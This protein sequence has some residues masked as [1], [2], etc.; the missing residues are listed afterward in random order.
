LR[1]DLIAGVKRIVVKIGSRVLTS[2]GEGLDFG[3]INHLVEQIS[4]LAHAGKE[5]FVVSSGAVAAGIK[6]LKLK[7]LPRTIPQK[8]AVA[9]VGQSHLIWAYEWAF[10][11]HQ[12][13]V[14]QVLLTH[15][16]LRHRARYLNARNTLLTLI[17][18]GTVP[19]INENDTVS[20]EEIKLGDN[21]SLSAMV[22]D[23]VQADLLLILTD[24]EGVYTADPCLDPTAIFLAEIPRVTP[25][26][27]AMGG[28][29]NHAVARGGMFTKIQAA[30]KLAASGI[31]TIVANGFRSGIIAALLAGESHGTL[32]HPERRLWRGRKR[33]IVTT[34]R[35]RGAVF[36]DEGAKTAVVSKG[37]SLLPSGILSV[38]GEFEFGDLVRCCDQAGFEFARG[39]VNYP[40]H[41]VR[42]IKGL[43]TSKIEPTLGHKYCD[44]VIHRDNLVVWNEDG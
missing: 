25:A 16:D 29:P 31:P 44:E 18:L 26:I 15:E 28:L 9:A 22:A 40:G 6:E 37:K 35:P 41:E 8:Q 24:I 3:V 42:L 19:I 32:F 30:K 14:A 13:R 2:K 33:W 17:R 4:D 12:Q 43:H 36:V 5:V 10:K 39:L 23:L 7:D 34:L 38:D 11:Q 21:D 20:V 27:E 1:K